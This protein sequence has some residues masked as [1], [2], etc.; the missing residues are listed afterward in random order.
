MNIE[1]NKIYLWLFSKDDIKKALLVVF[2]ANILIKALTFTRSVIFARFLTPE[3]LGLFSI[4]FA[5][6]YLIAPIVMLGAPSVLIRY[7]Y[8]YF[9]SGKLGSFYRTVGRMPLII[10]IGISLIFCLEAPLISRLTYGS[11]TYSHLII[12][13]GITLLPLNIFSFLIYMFQGMQTFRIKVFLEAIYNI[14]FFVIGMVFVL[15]I[16]RADSLLISNLLAYLFSII[17]VGFLF[18]CFSKKTSLTQ[19]SSVDKK[20]IYNTL[21]HFGIWSVFAEISFNLLGFFD[22]WAL[23]KMVSSEAAGIYFVGMGFSNFLF[24]GVQLLNQVLMPKFSELRDSD[25]K[26]RLQFYLLLI[27]KS[28]MIIF[29]V[30]SILL[31]IFSKVLI[32]LIYGTNYKGIVFFINILFL[33]SAYQL[34]Y[35][36]NNMY[37]M[38]LEKSFHVFSSICTGALLNIVFNF[39]LIPHF[40]MKG[41]AMATAIS[42]FVTASIL[43]LVN[44]RKGLPCD[45]RYI[46]IFLLPVGLFWE[47]YLLW[48]LVFIILIAWFLFTRQ[49]KNTLTRCTS[50]F[51]R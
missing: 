29:L 36:F 9:T 45:I 7:S 15:R 21:F 44:Y 51:G 14:M 8:R 50:F 49:E 46:F 5:G 12:I 26:N 33:A 4:A 43:S 11:I 41:A 47:K 16:N 23:N 28:S 35:Y 24:L 34:L 22:R 10:T 40:G 27:T 30:I 3:E 18:R 42:F 38:A 48:Y 13:A 2:M 39:L 31:I 32:P 25:Q 6:Y 17:I 1:L 37:A 19:E 20:E